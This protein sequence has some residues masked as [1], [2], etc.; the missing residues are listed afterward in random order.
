MSKK[1]GSGEKVCPENKNR[2]GN[3]LVCMRILLLSDNK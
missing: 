2:D 3:L 1:Y